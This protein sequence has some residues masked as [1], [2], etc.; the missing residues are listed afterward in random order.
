MADETITATAS[1][2]T[3]TSGT[4]EPEVV[5]G[6]AS[7]EPRDVVPAPARGRLFE[8]LALIA[9]GLVFGIALGLV[10]TPGR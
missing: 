8:P 4:T 1:T 5:A 10:T 3:A 9:L 2:S 7:G 6:I